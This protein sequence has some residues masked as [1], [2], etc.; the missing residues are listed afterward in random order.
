MMAARWAEVAQKRGKG[1]AKSLLTDDEELL[2]TGDDDETSEEE[3]V[4][5][6]TDGG[7]L[8]AGRTVDD[9]EPSAPTH[10]ETCDR[11]VHDRPVGS[12]RVGAPKRKNT[13][14][15]PHDG[16]RPYGV[17]LGSTADGGEGFFEE[18]ELP[19]GPV[20]PGSDNM[21]CF[22]QQMCDALHD[23]SLGIDLNID[24]GQV[25]SVESTVPYS[26]I[27]TSNDTLLN[28]G[29]GRSSVFAANIF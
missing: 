26:D 25:N 3:Y 29:E 19:P 14:H 5:A 23:G 13:A 8:D 1:H 27:S 16:Q 12:R 22:M 11:P 24:L 4:D 15:K 20:S 28:H 2:P 10:V 17:D 21:D 7:E 9:H 18:G 6:D